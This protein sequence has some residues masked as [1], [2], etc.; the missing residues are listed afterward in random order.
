MRGR[1]PGRAGGRRPRSRARAPSRSSSGP[2]GIRLWFLSASA[3]GARA[4]LTTRTTSADSWLGPRALATAVSGGSAETGRLPAS[5]AAGARTRSSNASR[6]ERRRG[7]RSAEGMASAYR[8]AAPRR[9]HPFSPRSSTPGR[10]GSAQ[11]RTSGARPLSSGS[12]TRGRGS[13]G[14]CRPGRTGRRTSRRCRASRGR[15]SLQRPRRRRSSSSVPG[16]RCC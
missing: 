7:R 12:S 14:R 10:F 15:P 3:P 5:S 11:G 2:A 9:A 4:L 1:G 6:Q 16:S 13:P 8:A